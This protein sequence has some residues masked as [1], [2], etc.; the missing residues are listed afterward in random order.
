MDESK[1]SREFLEIEGVCVQLSACV[2]LQGRTLVISRLTDWAPVAR[3][4]PVGQPQR[5]SWRA[6]GT[7]GGTP[8][9]IPQG[10]RAPPAGKASED[11]GRGGYL[12]VPPS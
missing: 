10:S 7:A 12:D 1:E 2:Q 5:R 4:V 3:G 11:A 6:G 8:T 9:N